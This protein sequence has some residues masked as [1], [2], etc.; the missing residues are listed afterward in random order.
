MVELAAEEARV[1]GCE[2]LH[3]DFR[4]ELAAFYVDA[5][6]FVPTPT[7]V[8]ATLAGTRA[9]EAQRA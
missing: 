1:A 2:W 9:R 4:D 5:I 6:G 3:A 7:G 8:I